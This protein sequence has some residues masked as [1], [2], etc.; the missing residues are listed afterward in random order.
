M[1]PSGATSPEATGTTLRA[2]SPP[3]SSPSGP[4]ANELPQRVSLH[5][6]DSLAASCLLSPSPPSVSCIRLHTAREK[7]ATTRRRLRPWLGQTLRLLRSLPVCCALALYSI[8]FVAG[9][10]LTFSLLTAATEH[11]VAKTARLS[12]PSRRRPDDL[13]AGST[14][15]SF[16]RQPFTRPTDRRLIQSHWDRCADVIHRLG[17]D[18]PFAQS[19]IPPECADSPVYHACQLVTTSS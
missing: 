19:P 15:L 10:S 4:A 6:T 1:Q 2:R 5:S 8:A 17:P 12:V 11:R 9:L 14:S 3:V 13:L 18:Q 7:G 16:L